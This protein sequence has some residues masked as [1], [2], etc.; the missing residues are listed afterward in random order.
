MHI[1]VEHDIEVLDRV[2]LRLILTPHQGFIN[3]GNKVINVVEYDPNDL[4]HLE[5]IAA[6]CEHHQISES[7]I[8]EAHRHCKHKFERLVM[9]RL[10]Q[11]EQRGEFNV[12]T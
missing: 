6:V 2:I 1:H 5:A 3:S 7:A 12:S 4:P 8:E 10:W 11:T 9:D